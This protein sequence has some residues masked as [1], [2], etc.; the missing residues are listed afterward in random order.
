V[1]LRGLTTI[2]GGYSIQGLTDLRNAVTQTAALTLGLVVGAIVVLQFSRS[3]AMPASAAGSS[4]GD[5]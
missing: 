3:L 1:A 2:D 4:P 5:S